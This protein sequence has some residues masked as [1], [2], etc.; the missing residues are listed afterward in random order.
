MSQNTAPARTART[1]RTNPTHLSRAAREL[2]RVSTLSYTQA[3]ALLRRTST[4]VD[5]TDPVRVAQLVA[6]PDDGSPQRQQRLDAALGYYLEATAADAPAQ[7]ILIDG[8]SWSENTGYWQDQVTSWILATGP[9]T[10]HIRRD[11]ATTFSWMI[12]GTLEG[13]SFR[14]D[15]GINPTLASAQQAVAAWV[16]FHGASRLERARSEGR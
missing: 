15:Q 16:S 10:A 7:P 5:L 6:G 14:G 9:W 8:A 4:P 1:A 2:Q 11:E 3:L 12:N 13:V